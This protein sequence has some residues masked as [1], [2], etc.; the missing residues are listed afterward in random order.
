[1]TVLLVVF[2]L[3]LMVGPVA[4][5]FYDARYAEPCFGPLAAAAAL[6]GAGLGSRIWGWRGT[7]RAL[8]EDATA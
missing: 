2:T 3:L 1:V 7:R 8:P 4:T 6:G 5:L